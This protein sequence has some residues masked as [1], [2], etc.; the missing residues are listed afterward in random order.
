MLYMP[1]AESSDIVLSKSIKPHMRE[2]I[3]EDL[4]RLEELKFKEPHP[5]LLKV[6]SLTDLNNQSVINWLEERV[7]YVIEENALS[8]FKMITKKIVY[9]EKENVVYPNHNVLPFTNSKNLDLIGAEDDGVTIMSNTGAGLYLAGKEEHKLY[10]LK[11]SQGL[12]RSPIKVLANSPRVGIIQIGEGLFSRG[13]MINSD[14]PNAV[15]N[16]IVRLSTFFHEARH[17]DGAG[18]SLAFAH[19]KCP[20]GHDLEGV[21]ACDENLNGPYTIGAYINLELIKACDDQCTLREKEMLKI[22]ALDSFNRVLKKTNLTK[23]PTTYWNDEP[24]SL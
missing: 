13:M 7:K 11:I 16:S 4:K 6:M 19:S 3:V 17:S 2:K 8:I 14:E 12:F 10:G 23:K 18:T 22:D 9:V 1:K 5:E 20:I 15:S 24:E 21:Y